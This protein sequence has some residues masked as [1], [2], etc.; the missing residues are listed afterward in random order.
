MQ[1]ED[2]RK[3]RL[4]TPGQKV[5]NSTFINS[6]SVFEKCTLKRGRYVVLATTFDPGEESALMMRVFSDEGAKCWY[7]MHTSFSFFMLQTDAETT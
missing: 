6:R 3:Y 7:V 1:V 4:H 5:I 2:N